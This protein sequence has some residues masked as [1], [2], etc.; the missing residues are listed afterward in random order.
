MSLL[1]FEAHFRIWNRIRKS[2]EINNS[3]SLSCHLFSLP[4][5]PLPVS[6]SL[7][8][9]SLARL[10]LFPNT[11]LSQEK[12]Q[13]FREFNKLET[14]AY[15]YLLKCFSAS[16]CLSIMRMCICVCACACVR[17]CACVFL[18][19]SIGYKNKVKTGET[20]GAFCSTLKRY[21]PQ[22]AS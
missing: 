3:L 6:S 9:F 8:P 15:T 14:Q 19:V 22:A 2:I 13:H 10:K 17:V 21:T 18:R 4:T 12:R 16:P 20:E 1:R 5:I 7:L 11:N